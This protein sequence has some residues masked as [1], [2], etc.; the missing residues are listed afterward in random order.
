MIEP[1]LVGSLV[2]ISCAIS[3]QVETGFSY[4]PTG[5]KLTVYSI[6][7]G[8]AVDLIDD[9]GNVFR[10]IPSTHVEHAK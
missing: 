6:S 10:D 7:S 9:E 3:T 5:S 2:R 4:H 1:I 8:S